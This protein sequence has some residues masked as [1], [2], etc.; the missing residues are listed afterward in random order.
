MKKLKSILIVAVVMATTFMMSTSVFADVGDRKVD[1]SK[2]K[3]LYVAESQPV[4]LSMKIDEEMGVVIYKV[5]A[6][7][8]GVYSFYTTGGVDTY[9]ALIDNNAEVISDCYVSNDDGYVDNGFLIDWPINA[10]E[11][12]YLATTYYS[13]SKVN[14]TFDL[15]IEFNPDMHYENNIIYEKYY[16]NWNGEPNHDYYAVAYITDRNLQEVTIPE[17]VKN[18]PVE[19]L[20]YGAC[21][22]MRKLQK[23][24]LPNSIKYIADEAFYSCVKLTSINIPNEIMYFGNAVFANTKIT[25]L[26]LPKT[27][28]EIGRYMLYK[29][30][31]FKGVKIASDNPNFK[32]VDGNVY[33]LDGKRLISY[34]R[35]D[36]LN[37]TVPEGVEVIDEHAFEGV[38][39]FRTVSLPSTLKEIG[40]RAF[41][42]STLQGIVIP[43]GVTL[44]GEEAFEYCRNLMY[45]DLPMSVSEVGNNCFDDTNIANVVIRNN[46]FAMGTDPFD[47]VECFYGYTSSTT[48]TYANNEMECAFVPIDDSSIGHSYVPFEYTKAPTCL[49]TGIANNRCPICNDMQNG[50]VVPKIGHKVIEKMGFCEGCLQYSFKIMDSVINKAESVTILPEGSAVYVY[51]IREAGDYTIKISSNDKISGAYSETNNINDDTASVIFNQ[52]YNKKEI[53]ETETLEAGYKLYVMIYNPYEKDIKVNVNVTKPTGT[54]NNGGNSTNNPVKLSQAKIVSLKAG[55]KS[56]TIKI[57]KLANAKSYKIQYATNKK[58]KKAKSKTISKLTYKIKKL[59]KGKKYFFRVCGVNGKVTGPWSK[60]KSVKIK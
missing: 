55:K 35:T 2:A 29:V 9:G 54:V 14:E 26:E 8:T 22:D 48:Q 38:C 59:K 19:A 42:E 49:E 21:A 45:I 56:A 1:I 4:T 11:S 46:V 34:M 12:V 47:Y 52:Y 16:D 6:A 10:G 31:N 3:N 25:S 17:K 41:A 5:T 50:M 20:K 53:V 30:K 24:T 39:D 28:K 58:M 60:K 43:E 51:D 32:S 37:V 27:V 15:H 36:R 23:V 44:I 33:S 13:D 57:A 40:Y 18:I 7:E